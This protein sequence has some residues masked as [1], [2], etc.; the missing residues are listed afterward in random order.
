MNDNNNN[1]NFFQEIDN[2]IISELKTNNMILLASFKQYLMEMNRKIIELELKNQYL[3]SLSS[4]ICQ[5]SHLDIN[6]FKQDY[7]KL[8]FKAISDFR[9]ISQK[10]CE[11]VYDT[12]LSLENIDKIKNDILKELATKYSQEIN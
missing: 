5:I 3:E 8:N 7:E 4:G 9:N 1:N 2:I 11:E 6:K 12:I 10:N